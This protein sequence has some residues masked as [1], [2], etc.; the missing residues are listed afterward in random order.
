[1]FKGRDLWAK[2][3]C[4]R[5]G[6]TSNFSSFLDALDFTCKA[7]FRMDNF[8][9]VLADLVIGD[10][11]VIIDED[12]NE[13]DVLIDIVRSVNRIEQPQIL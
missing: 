2:H 10:S 8:V 5:I 1:M 13:T 9:D 4:L 12:G 3:I 6:A 11:P 7:I